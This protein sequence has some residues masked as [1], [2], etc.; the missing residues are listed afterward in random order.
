MDLTVAQKEL[1]S[2][3]K[4][5]LHA[6]CGNWELARSGI[7]PNLKKK[8]L[9]PLKISRIWPYFIISVFFLRISKNEWFLYLQRQKKLTKRIF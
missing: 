6:V 4:S 2:A 8:K 7:I 9:Q 1:K 5:S 3:T